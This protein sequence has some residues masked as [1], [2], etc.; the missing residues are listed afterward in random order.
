MSGA[1]GLS[2]AKRR[3]GVGAT[4]GMARQNYAME[5]QPEISNG[6]PLHPLKLI[7]LH[8]NKLNGLLHHITELGKAFVEHQNEV[9]K[10]IPQLQE[11]V[12]EL[13][14]AKEEED[15][16]E[17]KSPV[18]NENV[19]EMILSIISEHMKQTMKEI[20]QIK[21]QNNEEQESIN[22]IS[23]QLSMLS[24]EQIDTDSKIKDFEQKTK[25]LDFN[26]KKSLNEDNTSNL[27][28]LFTKKYI[29][30]DNEIK[31]LKR[32]LNLLQ[33]AYVR[34][35][36]P[37][38]KEKAL[39]LQESDKEYVENEVEQ[40]N[41]TKDESDKLCQASEV[42]QAA[43]RGKLVRNSEIISEPTFKS[44]DKKKKKKL[45]VKEIDSDLTPTFTSGD[46]VKEV[47]SKDKNKENISL[48]TIE[49]E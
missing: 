44:V 22:S 10:A 33:N 40:V 21:K 37:G 9:S 27:K 19:R 30:Q 26:V 36:F 1:A 47:L 16:K 11:A 3:R 43:V 28:E 39:T 4:N 23:Q 25:L 31:E 17:R 49:E 7:L 14:L 2:A 15:K 5:E 34:E 24:A 38:K 32:E 41:Q 45:N 35:G 46:I 48:V 6:K 20:Q 13:L 12:E 42:I 8:E 29:E 18:G